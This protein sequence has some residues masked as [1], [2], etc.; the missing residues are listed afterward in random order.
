M[1]LYSVP[2]HEYANNGYANVPRSTLYSP[3]YMN[4]QM[5]NM[6]MICIHFNLLQYSFRCGVTYEDYPDYDRSDAYMVS[7]PSSVNVFS[8]S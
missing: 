2:F 7:M 8:N 4:M 3:P 5:L 1:H 6:L